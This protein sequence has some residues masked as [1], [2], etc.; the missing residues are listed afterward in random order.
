[1]LGYFNSGGDIKY[2]SLNEL[3]EFFDTGIKIAETLEFFMCQHTDN[4]DDL[5]ELTQ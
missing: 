5:K 4:I 1:M 3:S 2:Q